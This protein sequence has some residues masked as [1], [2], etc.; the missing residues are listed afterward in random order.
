MIAPSLPDWEHFF[1]KSS[2]H[3][4]LLALDN[5]Q[6]S[7]FWGGKIR[8]RVLSGIDTDSSDVIIMFIIPWDVY[9]Y[10]FAWQILK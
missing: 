6:I 9:R 7:I 10:P 8:H 3:S 5:P 4:T 2:H 1:A